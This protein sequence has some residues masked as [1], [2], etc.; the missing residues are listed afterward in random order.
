MTTMTNEFQETYPAGAAHA[1]SEY[2]DDTPDRKVPEGFAIAFLAVAGGLLA[3]C[4][5]VPLV[6]HL[7]VK[8]L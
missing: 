6:V 2:E 5:V 4:L 3:L 7:I 8:A 1:A